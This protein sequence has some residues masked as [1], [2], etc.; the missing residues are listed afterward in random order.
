[1]QPVLLLTGRL[2]YLLATAILMA[3]LVA[4]LGLAPA[5]FVSYRRSDN[6]EYFGVG[7]LAGVAAIGV[8]FLGLACIGLF[9]H[10]LVL[11]LF[12][13]MV[14]ASPGGWTT[15][16]VLLAAAREFL[17]V[18]AP[19]VL[20][21]A[22]CALPTGIAMLVPETEQDSFIY[23]LGSVWQWFQA[24]RLPID[25]VPFSFHLPLPVEMIYAIPLALGDDRIA[26]WMLASCFI[27]AS[28][29]YGSRMLR[30]GNPGAA[31]LGPIVA[32]GAAT[33]WHLLTMTK[34][35]IATASLFVTG[36]LF[37]RYGRSGIG[38]LFLGASFAS[39]LVVGPLVAIWFLLYVRR[40]RRPVFFFLM[41]C[42]PVLPWLAKA[43]LAT[44]N[45]V[46]PIFYGI[47]PVFSWDGRNQA[48]FR[49]YTSTLRSMPSWDPV[50]FFRAFFNFFLNEYILLL[51]ALPFLLRYGRNRLETAACAAGQ[52]VMFKIGL[53]PR[54][55]IPIDWLLGL[56]LASE[57]GRLKQSRWKAGATLALVAFSVW[58][59]GRSPSVQIRRWSDS[60]RPMAA[61]LEDQLTTYAEMGREISA[62]KCRRILL[63]GEIR[64]H[65][66]PAR[67]MYAGA[68]GETPVTWKITRES[69]DI[70]EMRKRFRQIGADIMV[71]N[72]VTG[73]NIAQ[74]YLAYSW[75][76]QMLARYQDFALSYLK[77]L[78]NPVGSD[79][80]NGCFAIIGMK[81]API[82]PF[83]NSVFSLPGAEVIYVRAITL[84]KR[85]DYPSEMAELSALAKFIPR[86]RFTMSEMARIRMM[87]GDYE[88][89]F[90]TLK[91]LVERGAIDE[92]ILAYYGSSAYALNR[93]DIAEQ[94]FRKHMTLYRYN[95]GTIG[96]RLA[97]VLYLRTV[98]ANASVP[99]A[100]DAA[101][102]REAESILDRVPQSPGNVTPEARLDAQAYI[103]GRLADY[104]AGRG[105]KAGALRLYEEAIKLAPNLPITAIWRGK[106]TGLGGL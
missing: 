78:N 99:S 85:G 80:G 86:V 104:L 34:N 53:V 90:Q 16:S 22:A 4:R 79:N 91:P 11:V 97:H 70:G 36:A 54:Y 84:E 37:L 2:V 98:H 65:R 5:R 33:F 39:K 12:A 40:V 101:L 23:H 31:W 20:L 43:W 42:I 96:Y 41:L 59:I 19:W 15:R 14:A 87:T 57:L 55:L 58:N 93:F 100:A 35:D 6:L 68:L 38:A 9:T 47:F 46:Y 28:S 3:E 62:M 67:V 64:T 73:F 24:G 88:G 76:T 71:L 32:M 1:M 21:V 17:A 66:I 56:Q 51:V 29:I 89:T 44:G 83:Q 74:Y 60:W 105:D 103:K 30:E 52:L 77:Q 7:Y 26:R 69:R 25:Y 50:S 106:R 92:S 63:V 102:L 8:A 82:L 10:T 48:V 13:V 72:Y 18:G 49:A 27:A 75:D 95:T 81:R 45:P 61:V 94:A